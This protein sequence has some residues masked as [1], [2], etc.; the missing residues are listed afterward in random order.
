MKFAYLGY[1]NWSEKILN[2]LTKEGWDID[3]FTPSNNEYKSPGKIIS[4]KKIQDLDFSDYKSLFFYG[5]SWI[6]PEKIIN[7]NHKVPT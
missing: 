7:E 4:P 5:W 2:N 1:R 3:K 6:I